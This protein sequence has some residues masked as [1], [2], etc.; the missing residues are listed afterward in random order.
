MTGTRA[1][2][3]IW[4]LYV[5]AAPS[6]AA[7]WEIR[8]R[9]DVATQAAT[10]QLQDLADIVGDDVPTEAAVE[11][12]VVA[13][14]PT[15]QHHRELT[16]SDVRRVLAARGV[17][18]RQCQ[19]AGAPRVVIVYGLPRSAAD[20]APGAGQPG[21]AQVRSLPPGVT[22]AQR[23]LEAVVA[24]RLQSLA[25]DGCPW[26]AE[27][28]WPERVPAALLR[29]GSDF[30]VESPAEATEGSHQLTVCLSDGP[31]SVRVPLEVR[32]HRVA[33]VVVP[34]RALARGEV[35]RAEDVVLRSV[36]EEGGRG[37][38]LFVTRLEDA[39]GRRVRQA[40]NADQP[41]STRALQQPLLVRRRDEV[42]VLVRCGAIRAHRRAVALQDGTRGD[43]VTVETTDGSKTQ[44]NARVVDIRQ[45]EVLPNSTSVNP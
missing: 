10:V 2:A 4:A 9:A 39:V 40:V 24:Q 23:R 17:D 15:P 11:R 25:G 12:I 37:G 43:L 41:L 42:D 14:G 13:L 7:G 27:V 1:V 45:V 6:S 22:T 34:V 19:F 3:A 21:R 26:K 20:S 31:N 8:L 29:A 33:P 32:A 28:A 38:A 44:F 35:I 16:R 36:E 5:L 18:L 30:T